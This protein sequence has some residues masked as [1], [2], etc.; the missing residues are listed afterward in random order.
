MSPV[1]PDHV[2]PTDRMMVPRRNRF[3]SESDDSS[4]STLKE[5]EE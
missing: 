2:V 5:E 1:T 3:V 4:T